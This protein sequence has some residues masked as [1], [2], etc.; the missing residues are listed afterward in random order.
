MRPPRMSTARSPSDYFDAQRRLKALQGQHGLWLAGLYAD[1]ADSHESAIRSAVTV[2][3]QLA[4]ES[5]RLN[6]MRA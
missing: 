1:D 3:E 6:R 5:P 2:A 4:P